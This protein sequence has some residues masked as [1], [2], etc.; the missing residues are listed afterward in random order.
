MHR[1]TSETRSSRRRPERL[2]RP[3]G[4]SPSRAATR[5]CRYVN[6]Q[7]AAARAAG[8]LVAYTQDWHPPPPPTSPGRRAL[9]VHCVAGTWAPRSTRRWTP[10]PTVRPEGRGREDGYSGFT[11]RDRAA[12]RWRPRI[13][14]APRRA[15]IRRVVVCGLATDYCVRATALDAL[16]LGYRR[17]PREGVRAVD[18]QPATA[19]RAPRARRGG[20]SCAAGIAAAVEAPREPAGESPAAGASG[21][22]RP[23]RRNAGSAR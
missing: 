18:L 15:R 17:H 4:S 1:A 10:A 2:R 6:G 22:G 12:T 16:A 13:S 9:P 20:V 11:V 19:E 23:W 8:A 5:S 14:P 21:L 7:I 3:A